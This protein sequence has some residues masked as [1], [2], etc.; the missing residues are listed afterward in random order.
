MTTTRQLTFPFTQV[1]QLL[2]QSGAMIQV[3]RVLD[4]GANYIVTEFTIRPNNILLEGDKFVNYS[5]L[6]VM[7]QSIG[8]WE[9]CRSY[10][11]GKPIRLGYFLG[12]RKIDFYCDA[13]EIGTTLEIKVQLSLQ[14]ET[15][16]G[17]FDVELFEK[18]SQKLLIKAALNV[19]SPNK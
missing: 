12:S 13:I 15:G 18:A 11:Q 16:F 8:C 17:V 14:D 6:E 7:A 10:S 2:P 4:Y 1:D 3:D 5:A 9:G 19:Y